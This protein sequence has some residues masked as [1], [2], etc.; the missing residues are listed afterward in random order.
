VK[1][2]EIKDPEQ[3]QPQK[4]HN[5]GFGYDDDDISEF[6]SLETPVPS[7]PKSN[8]KKVSLSLRLVSQSDGKDLDPN[9]SQLSMMLNKLKKVPEDQK[10]LELGAILNTTCTKCN[11][12][13]HL[14]IECFSAKT[15]VKYDLI[16]SP[17]HTGDEQGEVVQ[18]TEKKDEKKKHSKDKEKHKHKH[19]H[20]KKHKHEKE[21]D[22]DS[23]K[24]ESDSERHKKKSKHE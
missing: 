7:K 4:V 8:A 20:H 23:N 13:G 18:K 24:S 21:S 19:K 22:S 10:P 15:G 1:V 6:S 17:K 11:G 12:K 3:E 9:N 16:A 2:I 5:S 14:A